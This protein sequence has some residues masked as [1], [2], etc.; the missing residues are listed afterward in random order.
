MFFSIGAKA[1]HWLQNNTLAKDESGFISVN[2]YHQST[3]HANVF[4]AGDVCSRN[5]VMLPK[6][7]VYAVRAGEILAD[8]LRELLT[9]H[10]LN[11][12]KPYTPSKH[13]LQI[14]ALGNKRATAI[15]GNW[16]ISGRWVW[17]WKRF[18][19]IKFVKRFQQLT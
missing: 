6:A 17:Y 4:A 3:S 9:T 2:A 8:N 11:N 15:Y 13:V 10:S 14:L 16:V 7:G 19:D 1:P 12:L 5:D 18:I